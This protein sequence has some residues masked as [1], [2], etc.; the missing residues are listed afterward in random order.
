MLTS[1]TESFI[2]FE[3]HATIISDPPTLTRQHH[4]PGYLTITCK[5]NKNSNLPTLHLSWIP[6]STLRKFPTTLENNKSLREDSRDSQLPDDGSVDSRSDEKVDVCLE[7]K[8]PVHC[9]DCER[10]CSGGFQKTQESLARRIIDRTPCGSPHNSAGSKSIITNSSEEDVP[11]EKNEGIN[12][13]RL[14]SESV[15][16]RQG[17]EENGNCSADSAVKEQQSRLQE[18]SL[19]EAD[20]R[21]NEDEPI[22][23]FDNISRKSRSTSLTSNCSILTTVHTD[24]WYTYTVASN[25]YLLNH[26]VRRNNL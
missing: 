12:L 9:G 21:N 14:R 11:E 1:A 16:S 26:K 19:D 20:K 5:Y 25:V 13:S 18:I 3:I 17:V 6:N 24:G 2:L 23:S 10:I 8:E 4:H 15:N 7:V 22:L